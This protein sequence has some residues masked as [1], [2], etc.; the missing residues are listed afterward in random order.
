MPLVKRRVAAQ[1][2]R[3]QHAL[4]CQAAEVDGQGET[5]TPIVEVASLLHA[6]KVLLENNAPA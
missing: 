2:E 4:D 6:L 5:I 1:L 3:P